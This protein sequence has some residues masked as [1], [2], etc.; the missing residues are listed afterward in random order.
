[1]TLPQQIAHVP[2]DDDERNIYHYNARSTTYVARS[3]S[4]R[5]NSLAG[6]IAS[7]SCARRANLRAS[8][9][10]ASIAGDVRI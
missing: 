2:T 4:A 6:K 5:R 9:F 10:A 3:F 7:D 1:Q 8:S